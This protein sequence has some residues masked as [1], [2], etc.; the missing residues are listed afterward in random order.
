MATELILIS[1]NE[2]PLSTNSASCVFL[3]SM[4]MVRGS[5]KCVHAYKCTEEEERNLRIYICEQRDL[6]E[7]IFV[8][9]KSTSF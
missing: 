6:W 7:E 4:Q 8:D 3:L 5:V 9:L 1:N 2:S